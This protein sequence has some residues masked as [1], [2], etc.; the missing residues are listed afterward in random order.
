MEALIR[1]EF[2]L[3]FWTLLIFVLLVAI[4]SKTVWPPLINAIDERERGIRENMESAQK[5]RDE[6]EKIKNE[7]DERLRNLKAEIS[8]RLDEAIKTAND[9]KDKIMEKANEQA[10]VVLE[11]A[12]K[13]IEAKKNEVAKELEKKMM[14]VAVLVSEKALAGIIDKKMNSQ[15]VEALSREIAAGKMKKAGG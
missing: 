13:E 6:A 10:E 1:P 4:L 8:V 12:K 2:G 7:V 5:A 11:N 14:E 9:E 3:V 15:L